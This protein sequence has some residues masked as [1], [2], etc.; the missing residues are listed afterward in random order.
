METVPALLESSLID[1]LGV[2][3]LLN[4]F[5]LSSCF[6]CSF[7]FRLTVFQAF[8]RIHTSLLLLGRR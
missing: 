5:S 3:L 4:D 7:L 2:L 6:M 1:S 8:I